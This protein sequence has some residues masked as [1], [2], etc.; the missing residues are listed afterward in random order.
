MSSYIKGYLTSVADDHIIITVSD[1]KTKKFLTSIGSNHKHIDGIKKIT[2][3]SGNRCKIKLPKRGNYSIQG[4]TG[5]V[6]NMLDL[7]NKEVIANTKYRKYAFKP[8]DG[9]ITIMGYNFTLIN[10]KE[11]HEHM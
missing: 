2:P 6:C 1:E 5:D 9:N 8:P 7:L 4:S 10:I 11:L 3:Y